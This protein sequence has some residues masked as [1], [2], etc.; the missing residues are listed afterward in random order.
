MQKVAQLLC[1]LWLYDHSD[2]MSVSD[3]WCYDVKRLLFPLIA[4][5]FSDVKP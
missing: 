4:M 3:D 5:P 2:D 1:F